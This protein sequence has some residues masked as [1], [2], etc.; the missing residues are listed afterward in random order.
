MRLHTLYK[1]LYCIQIAGTH[2]HR[3]FAAPCRDAQRKKRDPVIRWRGDPRKLMKFKPETEFR[4]SIPLLFC[5]GQNRNYWNFC[6]KPQQRSA[7]RGSFFGSKKTNAYRRTHVYRRWQN[8]TEFSKRLGVM[9][10]EPEPLRP[11][12]PHGRIPTLARSCIY[13]YILGKK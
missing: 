3:T 11:H 8:W 6:L 13:I 9:W 4:Q 2:S 5:N 1:A 12:L 10:S 7:V